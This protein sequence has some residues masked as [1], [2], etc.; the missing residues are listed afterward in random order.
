MSEMN[1]TALAMTSLFPQATR[2]SRPAFLRCKS[3]LP[4]LLLFFLSPCIDCL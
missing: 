2:A 1:K 3:C 4:L